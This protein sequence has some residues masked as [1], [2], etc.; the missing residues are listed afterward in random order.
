M[1]EI[2]LRT[3]GFHLNEATRKHIMKRLYTVFGFE[4]IKIKKLIITFS[5][6]SKKQDKSEVSCCIH[7][8]VEGQPRITTEHKAFDLFSAFSLAIEHARLKTSNRLKDE[9][10]FRKQLDYK[11]KPDIYG[12]RI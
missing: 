2:N 1:E 5:N 6:E 3:H 12:V 11:R 10:H 9:K 8:K 4:E 7:I